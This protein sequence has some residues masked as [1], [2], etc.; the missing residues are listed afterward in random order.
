MQEGVADEAEHVEQGV[1]DDE[2]PQAPRPGPV[3]AAGGA[4]DGVAQEAA[5][6]LVEVVGAAEQ[7]T[8]GHR[9]ARA[10]AALAPA[11]EQIGDHDGLLEQAVR[12]GRQDV[13]GDGPHV[14]GQVAGGD[15]RVD[16]EPAGEEVEGQAGDADGRR[17]GHAGADVPAGARPVQADRP[18]RIVPRAPDGGEQV[19]D[20]DH[21]RREE[22]VVGELVAQV[23][24]GAV[25]RRR[26]VDRRRLLTQ[27]RAQGQLVE[28][29]QHR[30]DGRPAQAHGQHAEGLQPQ[31]GAAPGRRRAAGDGPSGARRRLPRPGVRPSAAHRRPSRLRA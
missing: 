31:T 13:H 1:R 22:E 14:L 24:P 9:R 7:G 8:D 3:Q 29:R 19:Q 12:E 17:Q 20:D 2:R 10:P 5:E 15:V 26:A 27:G 16:A 6:A 18:P 11:G 25:R 30:V 21:R 23:E 4:H 28:D